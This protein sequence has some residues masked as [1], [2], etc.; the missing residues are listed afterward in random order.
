MGPD[1]RR[2]RH[3]WAT[4]AVNPTQCPSGKVMATAESQRR[5]VPCLSTLV[6]AAAAPVPVA[7]STRHSQAL[8]RATHGVLRVCQRGVPRRTTQRRTLLIHARCGTQAQRYGAAALVVLWRGLLQSHASHHWTARCRWRAH[9]AKQAQAL[10]RR[11]RTRQLAHGAP[12]KVRATRV[13]APLR[14][15]SIRCTTRDR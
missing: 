9:A 4:A 2:R 3:R 1:R 13:A 15:R 8:N 7:A 6:G 12:R 11:R 5:H 10:P 14:Q